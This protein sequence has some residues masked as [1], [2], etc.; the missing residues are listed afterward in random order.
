MSNEELFDIKLAIRPVLLK[1]LIDYPRE[2][3]LPIFPT[4]GSWLE[5]VAG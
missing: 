2:W 5:G 3:S 4:M 1:D